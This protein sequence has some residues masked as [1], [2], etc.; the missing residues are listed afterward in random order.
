[1]QAAD[2]LAMHGSLTPKQALDR[3]QQDLD[4]ATARRKEL[5]YEQ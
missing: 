1:V 5:G 2:D 4:R 3:L